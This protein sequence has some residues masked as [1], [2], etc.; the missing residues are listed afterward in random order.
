[1]S[2]TRLSALARR[3]L[4]LRLRLKADRLGQHHLPALDTARLLAK[5][6]A[7]SSTAANS[8]AWLAGDRNDPSDTFHCATRTEPV[9]FGGSN[10]KTYVQDHGEALY[11]RSLYSFLKRTAPPPFMSNCDAP[12][13]E[14]SCTRK[15]SRSS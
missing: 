8:L 11:R 15:E 10:T 1:M 13:R 9:A 6:G 14:K 2:N 7:F 5:H 12:N 3:T 4:A